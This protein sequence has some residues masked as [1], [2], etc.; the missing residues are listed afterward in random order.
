M[1][2]YSTKKNKNM[3]L[4]WLS[5]I[6]VIIASF[7]MPF[8]N[9]MVRKC[10]FQNFA[11]LANILGL[12]FS[13]SIVYTVI[14]FLVSHLLWKARCVQKILGI[15]NLSGKWECVGKGRKHEKS[16]INQW[17]GTIEIQQ[18]MDKILITLKTKDSNSTSKSLL[19]GLNTIS[20]TECELLYRY[21]NEPHVE[22][23]E[24]HRHTGS[25]SL[26]FDL[27][28]NTAKGIYFTDKDR[29]SFGIMELRKE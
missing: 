11:Q 6:S 9:E 24:L 18:T 12:S 15:P 29:L 19:A 2:E 3:F 27:K 5:V 28:H 4:F 14:Y 10:N 17:C 1:H 26:I 23:Q 22:V 8:L 21:E 25:C 20:I 7:V 13:A 16:D